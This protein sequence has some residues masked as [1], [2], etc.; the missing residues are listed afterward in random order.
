M[1]IPKALKD[2]FSLAL[3]HINRI[4][5]RENPVAIY[6]FHNMS[7]II[8]REEMSNLNVSMSELRLH[9][10]PIS[11]VMSLSISILYKNIL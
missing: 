1:Y 9:Y 7:R 4:W 10:Q 5:K 11:Q 2:S 6:A 3:M 8:V